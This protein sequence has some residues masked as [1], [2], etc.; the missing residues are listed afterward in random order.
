MHLQL[1]SRIRSASNVS[2]LKEGKAI[3]GDAKKQIPLTRITKVPG[4]VVKVNLLT[5]GSTA[6][7]TTNLSTTLATTSLMIWEALQ[8]FP[9]SSQYEQ[10]Q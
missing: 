7:D 8:G 10:R 1:L 3:P 5:Q 6:I 2:K 4:H 9:V